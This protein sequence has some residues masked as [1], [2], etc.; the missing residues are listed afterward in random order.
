MKSQLGVNISLKSDIKD[1][2]ASVLTGTQHHA[3]I[4]INFT[5]H[6]CAIRDYLKTIETPGKN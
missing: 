5:E 1:D 3:S 4:L 2:F 6:P